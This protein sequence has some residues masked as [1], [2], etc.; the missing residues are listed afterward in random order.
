MKRFLP[1]VT[2]NSLSEVVFWRLCDTVHTHYTHMY[3]HIYT[4]MSVYG[5][6]TD[7]RSNSPLLSLMFKGF[8]NSVSTCAQ[9]NSCWNLFPVQPCCRVKP[10]GNVYRED[11]ERDCLSSR[12]R[13]AGACFLAL[14]RP[15]SVTSPT[16]MEVSSGEWVCS[17]LL[18]FSLPCRRC[19]ISKGIPLETETRLSSILISE[20]Q[21]SEQCKLPLAFNSPSM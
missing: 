5:K 18:C 14:V 12:H 17:S 19:S 1:H 21:S 13:S 2:L 10:N 9:P 16:N 11:T 20:S 4:H 15:C 6:K 3:A 7:W 8:Y